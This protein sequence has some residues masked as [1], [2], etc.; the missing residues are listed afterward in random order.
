[1]TCR[2]EGHC[3]VEPDFPNTGKDVDARIEYENAQTEYVEFKRLTGNDLRGNLFDNVIDD[4]PS[5][6]SINSRYV[7]IGD[8]TSDGQNI[9][10]ITVDYDRYGIG[11]DAQ[12]EV[13]LRNEIAENLD[14]GPVENV[15]VDKVRI[16]SANGSSFE[17][18]IPQ[19]DDS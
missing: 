5:A 16:K 19:G 14:D 8:D 3:P 18:D 2:L 4:S 17:V 10:E 15:A 9:G 7:K 1:M 6:D 11:S 12:I 13:I